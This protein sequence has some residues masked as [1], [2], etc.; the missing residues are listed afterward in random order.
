MASSGNVRSRSPD[1]LGN[2]TAGEVLIVLYD[3]QYHTQADLL[4]RHAKLF[5]QFLEPTKAAKL[6][7]NTRKKG[8]NTIFR[9]ELILPKNEGEGTGRWIQVVS[10][11]YI[12]SLS[13]TSI[14][15]LERYQTPSATSFALPSFHL[16]LAIEPSV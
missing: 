10:S 13:F 3:K 6:N 4:R 14:F 2:L 11:V 5:E 1:A 7:A 12:L 15:Q 9:L 8:V 16:C